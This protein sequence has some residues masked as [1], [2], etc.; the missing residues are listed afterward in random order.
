[1][2]QRGGVTSAEVALSNSERGVLLDGVTLNPNRVYHGTHLAHVSCRRY[3]HQR[4]RMDRGYVCV[5]LVQSNRGISTNDTAY[6]KGSALPPMLRF[7]LS[8]Q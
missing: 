5:R 3:F 1:M 4:L 2:T 6:K 8:Y 7:K